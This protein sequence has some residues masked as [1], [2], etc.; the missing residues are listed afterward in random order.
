MLIHLIK[1]GRTL[2][3]FSLFFF[4]HKEATIFFNQTVSKILKSILAHPSCFTNPVAIPSR[5]PFPLNQ[6]HR[7][8]YHLTAIAGTISP[9]VF[10]SCDLGI[11]VPFS[12]RSVQLS[13]V[14]YSSSVDRLVSSAYPAWSSR[15][16]L[17]VRASVSDISSF[18]SRYATS[19]LDETSRYS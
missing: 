18:I 4:F 1:R 5:E 12:F 13:Y 10:L 11:S 19:D 8:P 17:A 7:Q 2:F 14:C 15:L 9:L 6:I 3:L 16:S